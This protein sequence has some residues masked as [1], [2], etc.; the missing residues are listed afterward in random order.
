MS[1][2][3][4]LVIT[5][6]SPECLVRKRTDG[7]MGRR[8]HCLPHRV[9][10]PQQQVRPAPVDL[11]SQLAA[12]PAQ[13]PHRYRRPPPRHAP[14]ELHRQQRQHKQPPHALKGPYP[15]IF[16]IQA[17]LLAEAVAVLN[18]ASQPP[19]LIHPPAP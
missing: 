8:R 5:H 17:L 2:D 6:N 16:D 13:L 1:I 11:Q 10:T 15:H 14:N 7:E 18:S 3:R 19:V 12:K 4:Y 9:Q